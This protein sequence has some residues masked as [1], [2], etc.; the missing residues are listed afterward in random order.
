LA[1]DPDAEDEEGTKDEAIQLRQLRPQDRRAGAV[2]LVTVLVEKGAD[3]NAVG[4][5]G[6]GASGTPLWWAVQV[7]LT[8]VH[9]SAQPEPNLTQT[10]TLNT[11]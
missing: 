7:G 4:G 3:V 9:F 1:K 8:L 2:A 10:H 5:A 11:A 6:D